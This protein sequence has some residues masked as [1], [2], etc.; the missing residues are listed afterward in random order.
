ML[1]S[2]SVTSAKI[3]DG[4]IVTADLADNAI[5]NSKIINAAVSTDKLDNSAVT[6]PKLASMGATTGQ[7]LTYNGTSWAPNP[8]LQEQPR[9]SCLDRIYIS[10]PE[11]W[12]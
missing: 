12:E 4:T 9:G 2:N 3:F 8:F 11:K 10:I 7:V 6:S 5:T 1:A